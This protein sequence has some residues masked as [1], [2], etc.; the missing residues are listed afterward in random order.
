MKKFNYLMMAAAMTLG[1]ASCSQETNSGS[2]VE[3]TTTEGQV[4]IKEINVGGF[5]GSTKG[6]YSYC[7]GIILYN[8]GGTSVKL[9]NFG[10]AIAYPQT[11]TSASTY[12]EEYQSAGFIPAVY[13]IWYLPGTISIEPYSDLIVAV[14]GAIDH[15]KQ[16]NGANAFDMSNADIAMYD[17]GSEY[18]DE[19]Y[20]PT[21]TNV[22]S[23]N[24]MKAIRFNTTGKSWPIPINS[25]AIVLFQVPE[26]V[27]PAQYF[28]N[29][30]NIW[31]PG[32]TRN[33][34]GSN[35]C[36]KIPNKWIVDGV[37]LFLN[38]QLDKSN[39]RLTNDIDAG[40]GIYVISSGYSAYRNIDEK[41]TVN[42][43]DNINKLVYNYADGVEGT[44]DPSG[45]DAAASAKNGAKI[46]YQDTNNSTADFHL[47]K[48]WSL[49]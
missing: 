33:S 31:Y 40:Y 10:F 13:G 46:I 21:P 34:N 2:P 39:K 14:N 45:I 42:Y 49:K 26:G 23:S 5:K 8:N 29:E 27:E 24:W 1:L 36:Y 44:T 48:G 11:A 32:G 12:F 15:T 37:E 38:S 7:K 3:D 17:M 25:P 6:N 16:E 28:T 41:A 43:G 35:T 19:K 20:Y 9:T 18:T 47:R 22:P 4:I 30:E